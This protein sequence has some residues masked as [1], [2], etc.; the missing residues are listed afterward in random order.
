MEE[1]FSKQVE[2][3]REIQ[4]LLL[5]L[6]RRSFS[7]KWDKKLGKRK[8]REGANGRVIFQIKNRVYLFYFF[9]QPAI[10]IIACIKRLLRNI[11]FSSCFPLPIS[12]FHVLL[13]NRTSDSNV[14]VE[15]STL[16][17]FAK[18]TRKHI[19]RSLS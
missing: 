18:F 6:R 7:Q 9:I 15:K 11:I 4:Q 17:N 10:Q 19:C 14:F 1:M 13:Y 5:N 16:K 3:I 2:E 8:A 12:I